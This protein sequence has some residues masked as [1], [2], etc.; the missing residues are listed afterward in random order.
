MTIVVINNSIRHKDN[1][2]R[3]I[4]YG[5]YQIIGVEHEI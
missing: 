2:N 3:E 1:K 5:F 4:F